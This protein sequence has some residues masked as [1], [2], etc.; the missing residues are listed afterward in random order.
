MSSSTHE[1][2]ETQNENS[3]IHC[4]GHISDFICIPAVHI[5]SF[6]IINLV[7][8]YTMN[9]DVIRLVTAWLS[10]T[11]LS[12]RAVI[13]S[14]HSVQFLLTQLTACSLKTIQRI[15]SERIKLIVFYAICGSSV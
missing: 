9:V 1:R 7:D 6:C 5:I 8:S 14:E 12:I 4:D 3:V 11:Q 15:T 10:F 13:E 2:N